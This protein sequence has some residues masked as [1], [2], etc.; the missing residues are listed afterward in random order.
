MVKDSL[1]A[2]ST[3]HECI[4]FTVALK[5]PLWVSNLLKEITCLSTHT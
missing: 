1:G 4:A 5:G 3:F 2:A